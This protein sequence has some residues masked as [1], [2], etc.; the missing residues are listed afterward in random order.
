MSDLEDTT[1]ITPENTG[2]LGGASEEQG[3]SG[4]SPRRETSQM[5]MPI[6][7]LIE[8]HQGQEV[9][10]AEDHKRREHEMEQRV[11]EMHK[12][13]VTMRQLCPRCLQSKGLGP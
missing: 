8:D 6:Q 7:M 4:G 2:A 5:T 10:V 13:V 11:E 9:E 3:S 1:E 12:Q